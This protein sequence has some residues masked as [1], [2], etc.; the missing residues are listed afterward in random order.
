[1]YTQAQ[2]SHMQNTEFHT[3]TKPNLRLSPLVMLGVSLAKQVSAAKVPMA[4]K[5][6]NISVPVTKPVDRKPCGT[7]ALLVPMSAS[8]RPLRSDSHARRHSERGEDPGA[9]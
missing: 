6:R 9:E 3:T 4:P 1:M 8:R 5:M 2:T 7:P